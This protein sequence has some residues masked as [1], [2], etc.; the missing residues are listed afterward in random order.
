MVPVGNANV[1]VQTAGDKAICLAPLNSSCIIDKV[2]IENTGKQ[3][4]KRFMLATI[5]QAGLEDSYQKTMPST[6]FAG[7]SEIMY[8]EFLPYAIY[9]G[10]KCYLTY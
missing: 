2:K 9:N 7:G 10:D 4:E 3:D 8:C 6:W 5:Y 1:A